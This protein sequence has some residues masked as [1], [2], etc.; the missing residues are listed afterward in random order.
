M[1]KIIHIY[2]KLILCSIVVFF[3]VLFSVNAQERRF[4]ASIIAGVNAAQID[5]DELAGFHRLG[6]T[7]GLRG[8]YDF[9]EKTDLNV[10][11]LYSERGS[12]PNIFNPFFD[13]DINIGLRYIELPVY[14]RFSDW[15]HEDYYKIKVHGGL[16]YGRLISASTIDGFSADTVNFEDIANDFNEN[17]LSWIIGGSF[18]FSKRLGVT[19]RYT[20]YINNLYNPANFDRTGRKLRS[21]FLTFRFEYNL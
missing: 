17:D 13:P 2:N 10:E 20:R 8:G 14:I 12:R 3:G 19:F 21:Y 6:L 16:S 15:L 5:G 11:F 18:F 9:S 4:T 1:Q 7:G